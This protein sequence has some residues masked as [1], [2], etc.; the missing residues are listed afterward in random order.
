M[1]GAV[2][3]ERR[4]R[5]L[6]YAAWASVCFFWGT[7]Y[8]AI[9][10]GLETMPPALFSGLR[11]GLAGLLLGAWLVARGESL[12]RGREWLQLSLIGLAL[13][14]VGNL[15]VVSAQQWVPS[16]VA[17]L[18]IALS[19][20]WMTGIDSLLPD[21]ERITHRTLG[22]LLLGLAGLALLF[23]PRLQDGS[24]SAQ[25]LIGVG[26]IQVG[27]AS[28]S[29]GSIY[30]RRRPFTVKPLMG[31]AVQMA[32]AGAALTLL[33]TAAGDWGRIGFSSRS[34]AAFLYLLVFG[35]IVAYGSYV[36]ALQKLPISTVS[37]HAYINPIIAVV[38]GW[39]LLGEPLSW[40]EATAVA[41]ILAAVA[42]V[43]TGPVQPA[44]KPV[45]LARPSRPSA[46]TVSTLSTPSTQARWGPRT[47]APSETLHERGMSSGGSSSDS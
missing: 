24:F 47:R 3:V 11:L 19:P 35:S 26:I 34:V 2:R 6:A 43:R 40:R 20:F 14:G 8:V 27:A 22:G 25:M 4:E 30:S 13:L 7:T 9:A 33:G 42:I 15:C 38:L 23:A 21:G 41:V 28:W 44:P 10:I 46:S 32:A 45:E 39:L 29:A 18:V 12:P 16:G 31:A 17:A 37:L 1:S 5:Q 36:Y